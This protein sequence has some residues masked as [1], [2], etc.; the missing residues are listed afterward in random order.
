M[1]VFL[2]LMTVIAPESSG[3]TE[4]LRRVCD[5]RRSPEAREDEQFPDE[6]DTP[7]EVAARVRFHKYRGLAS[8]RRSAW[9]PRENLPPEYGR[10]F[11]FADFERTRRQALRED[12]DGAQVS[13][14]WAACR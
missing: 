12:T 9:D 2:S 8:F 6:M 7:K 1:D 13:R 3:G 11:Q 4:L 5:W 14:P 10:C